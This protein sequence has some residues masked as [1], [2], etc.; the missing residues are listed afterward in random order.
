MITDNNHI[1]LPTLTRRLSLIF[2]LFL[3]FFTGL[4]LL[5]WEPDYPFKTFVAG[6][7]LVMLQFPNELRSCIRSSMNG[8]GIPISEEKVMA[9]TSFQSTCLKK[10]VDA[11][12]TRKTCLEHRPYIPVQS[13]IWERDG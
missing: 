8:E 6:E 12:K 11:G 3:T 2:M 13:T 9:M 7:G 5:T 4:K 10:C 1:H